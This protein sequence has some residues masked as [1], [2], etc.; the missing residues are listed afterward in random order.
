M[1]SVE[2]EGEPSRVATWVAAS[3]PP[4]LWAAVVPVLVGGALAW[5]DDV[6][7]LEIFA[8]TLG[9]AVAIQIATNFANDASD[10]KRGADTPD[11]TGPKRAVASGLLTSRQ[12]WTGVWVMFVLAAAGGI[13]LATQAGLVII[14]VGVVSILAALAYTGG[15]RPYGYAGWGEVF[16][17]VFFGVVATVG[18]RFV[19]DSTL[20]DD[21][22]WISIPV[23]F[24]A[25]AILVANNLR[26]IPTDERTGKRTLAVRIG[27]RRTRLLYAG[28]M[29]LGTLLPAVLALIELVPLG[30]IAGSVTLVTAFGLVGRVN[31]GLMGAELVPVLKGTAQVQMAVGVLIA[32]GIVIVA[33]VDTTANL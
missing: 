26:D 11:R 27:E 2:P 22:W 12:M 14:G 23:G 24:L 5:D 32:V 18:S 4:T 16:V 9:A 30:A 6:F 25:T 33:V 19:H 10:A 8:V 28:L 31:R 17:F 20:P 13:Y 1:H 3:R 15:P 29:I 7:R 21:A